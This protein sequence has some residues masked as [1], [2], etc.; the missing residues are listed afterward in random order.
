MQLYDVVFTRNIVSVY[1]KKFPRKLK[2]KRTVNIHMSYE[3]KLDFNKSK[4]TQKKN[5]KK[6]A[7]KP[8]ENSIE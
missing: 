1:R 5:K 6:N 2:G 4:F 3:I 7:C 8:P